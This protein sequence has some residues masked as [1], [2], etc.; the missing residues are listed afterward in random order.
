MVSLFHINLMQFSYIYFYFLIIEIMTYFLCTHLHTASRSLI[1]LL[2]QSIIVGN[3]KVRAVVFSIECKFFMT[4][5][6]TYFC[7]TCLHTSSHPFIVSP[8]PSSITTPIHSIVVNIK[9]GEFFLKVEWKF[10]MIR[11]IT[12]F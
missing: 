2:I 10:C 5:L 12:Y 6:I 1:L 9:V 8:I 3:S 11:L 4:R 7:C